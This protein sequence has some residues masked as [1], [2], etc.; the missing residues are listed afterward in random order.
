MKLR[1][2]LLLVGVIATALPAH[3]GTVREGSDYTTSHSNFSLINAWSYLTYPASESYY[4]YPAPAPQTWAIYFQA[5]HSGSGSKSA[6]T[7]DS[8]SL[9]YRGRVYDAS[10]LVDEVTASPLVFDANYIGDNGTPNFQ[11]RSHDG[12][13]NDEYIDHDIGSTAA[14]ATTVVFQTG[15]TTPIVEADSEVDYTIYAG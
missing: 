12:N 4:T 6:I 9:S 2:A 10:I 5:Q 14:Y 11:T 7:M 8:V 13:N 15:D 3:A 1:L